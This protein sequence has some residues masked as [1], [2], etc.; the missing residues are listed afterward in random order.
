[1]THS[2]TFSGSISNIL[3]LKEEA[4]G[5]QYTK[6]LYTESVHSLS[7]HKESDI[8]RQLNNNE[9]YPDTYT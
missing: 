5:L 4:G 6:S 1:M 2:L 8:T 7:V 3:L 9:D